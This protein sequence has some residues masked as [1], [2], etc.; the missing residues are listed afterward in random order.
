MFNEMNGQRFPSNMSHSFSA[1]PQAEIQRSSF[2]RVFNYKTT[3]NSGYL[4]P[5][6]VDEAL[7]GDTFNLK[8]STLARL[9][10]PLRPV[11]DNMYL[12]T[13][14][15][16]VPY[17][18]V[19]DNWEKMQ[20]AQTDPDDST[21]FLVP[22]MV[23]PAETG[24]VTGSLEDYFGLPLGIPGLSVSSLWHRAYNLVWNEWFR[25]QNIQ[26][27]LVVDKDDGPDTPA[28]YVL[29]RR[30]KRHDYFTSALPWPQKGESVTF[31]IGGS[32]PV[33]LRADFYPDHEIKFKSAGNL[34]EDMPAYLYSWQ[35]GSYPTH[36]VQIQSTSSGNRL[37][38]LD[39]NGS[40]IA[41]L[42]NAT[43]VSVNTFRE[44]VQLQRILERD[45]RG[46]TRYVEM[47]KAHF[48]VISPD[49]RLQRPEYL[50]GGSNPI[51]VSA[52]P[53]TS[54]STS[55]NK[56]GDLA[57]FGTSQG[58]GGFSKSFVEHCLIIGLLNVRADLTYQQG[59]PRMFS[60]RTRY[61]FFMPATANLGEQAILNKEIFAQGNSD[62]EKAFGYQERWGEYRYGLS[63]I[64]GKFR[65]TDAQTLDI[66]H[67]SQEFATCPTLSSEFIEENPPVQRIVAVQNEP[68]FLFD[69]FFTVD[70][71]RPMPLFS[72]PGLVDHF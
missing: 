23:A 17:R 12:D 62:D 53:Q 63:K 52:I 58:N 31:G 69:S 16:A 29:R 46:G 15:F 10:T 7:P 2:K 61:D 67:L 70:T 18:L 32:A 4:V 27:S 48:G 43:A 34:T 49:F 9:A 60:R 47:I 3:F 5:F 13:F 39:P 72:V 42:S 65:S 19:W 41:D 21:D 38:A 40:L 50:G 37:H 55:T 11:M 26:D 6:Y 44:A 56:L 66:W 24:W 14:F 64:T 30:G 1:V 68:E 25:D 20:G 57:A 8:V 33:N 28:D 35:G 59:I 51:N 36:D 45:A 71:A 22:Q 54:A